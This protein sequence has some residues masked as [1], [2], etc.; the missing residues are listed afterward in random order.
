MEDGLELGVQSTKYRN[1]VVFVFVEV[2]SSYPPV[3]PPNRP[4]HIT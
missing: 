3:H 2:G 1:K 4:F